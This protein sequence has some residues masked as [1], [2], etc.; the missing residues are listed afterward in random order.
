MHWVSILT[1]HF[2]ALYTNLNQINISFI[3]RRRDKIREDEQRIQG[4]QS[5]CTH[6][7]EPTPLHNLGSRH[8]GDPKAPPTHIRGSSSWQMQP[9]CHALEHSYC[10]WRA[11]T[12]LWAYL[13]L[14]LLVF[15]TFHSSFTCLGKETGGDWD[16][17]NVQGPQERIGGAPIFEI[18]H[19]CESSR[20]FSITYIRLIFGWITL[21]SFIDCLLQNYLNLFFC[22]SIS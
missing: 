21:C 2:I 12:G 13:P 22:W 3:S 1:I 5:T 14:F 18:S 15:L 7:V 20:C 16:W 4:I 10:S 17:R 8:T 9:N 6:R 11:P 19:C